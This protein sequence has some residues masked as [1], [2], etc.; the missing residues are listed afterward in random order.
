MRAGSCG[1]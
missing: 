1:R